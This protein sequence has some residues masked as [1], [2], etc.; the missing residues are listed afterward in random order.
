MI[1]SCIFNIS[2]TGIIGSIDF[3]EV[4]SPI[5]NVKIERLQGKD[6]S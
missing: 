1:V 5:K 2:V 4:D 6:D 3:E